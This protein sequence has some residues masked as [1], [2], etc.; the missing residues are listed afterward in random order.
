[1]FVAPAPVASVSAAKRRTPK[2]SASRRRCGTTA[3][4][5]GNRCCRRSICSSD[6]ATSSSSTNRSPPATSSTTT[7]AAGGGKRRRTASPIWPSTAVRTGCRSAMTRIRSRLTSSRSSW[8]APRGRCSTSAAARCSGIVSRELLRNPRRAGRAPRLHP[9]SGATDAHLS[10]SQSP[11]PRPRRHRSN[12]SLGSDRM[13]WRGPTLV[14]PGAGRASGTNTDDRKSLRSS[15]LDPRY[16]WSSEAGA[17]ALLGGCP[18][19]WKA[20][21]TAR[22]WFPPDVAATRR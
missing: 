7:S 19:A 4:P 18:L 8:A 17:G 13:Y 2:V 9:L 14:P 15:S 21:A 22:C 20:M 3:S 10:S 16:S 11:A 1:M 6:G 5:T 12:G